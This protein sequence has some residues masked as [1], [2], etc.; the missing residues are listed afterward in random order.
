MYDHVCFANEFQ[1]FDKLKASRP[2][3]EMPLKVR[4]VQWWR[5]VVQGDWSF[6]RHVQVTWFGN[7]PRQ[8]MDLPSYIT[9]EHK[10]AVAI[11]R[12]WKLMGIC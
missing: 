7:A 5:F 11:F 6:Q 12:A 9:E 8:K 3:S 2:A 10:E 1:I 4:G